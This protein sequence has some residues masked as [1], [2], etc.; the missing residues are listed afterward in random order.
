[1]GQRISRPWPRELYDS[2]KHEN[3]TEE[4]PYKVFKV[5]PDIL[6]SSASFPFERMVFP[7]SIC[8]LPFQLQL[9]NQGSAN[10]SQKVKS[11][12][13]SICVNKVLLDHSLVHLLPTVRSFQATIRIWVVTAKTVWPREHKHLP[14]GLLQKNIWWTLLETYILTDN[15]QVEMV[16]QFSSVQW[17]SRVWLFATAW[18]AARQASLSITSPRCPPKPMSIESGMPW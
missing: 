2:Q 11:R 16:V 1:M 3:N 15:R 8:F 4:C 6:K 5:W 13:T 10:H 14:P 17:L 12:P 9:I 18:T 7:T